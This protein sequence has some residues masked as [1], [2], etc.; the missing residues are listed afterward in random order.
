MT[1]SQTLIAECLNYD[2]G[3]GQDMAMEAIVNKRDC[4]M[5]VSV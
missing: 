4:L 5:F 3:A 2:A 1:C